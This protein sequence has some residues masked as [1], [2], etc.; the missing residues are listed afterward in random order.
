MPVTVMRD[1]AKMLAW[2]WARPVPTSASDAFFV[3]GCNKPLP[4]YAS[5]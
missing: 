2:Q 3:T 5:S 1:R 4:K